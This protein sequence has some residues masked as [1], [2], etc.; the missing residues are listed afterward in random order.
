MGTS[1]PSHV[2]IPSDVLFQELEGEAVL[3]NLE[4]ERYYGLDDVGTR[5]WQLMAEDGDVLSA[6]E[7]LSKE[8]DVPSEVLRRDIAELIS[9]LSQVGLLKVG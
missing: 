5:I 9:K 3:L 7:Q 8:Y 2:D 4:T 1:L 6:F